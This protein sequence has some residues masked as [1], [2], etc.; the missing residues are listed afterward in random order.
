[1]LHRLV[2][3]LKPAAPLAVIL[4]LSVALAACGAKQEA[5]SGTGTGNSGASTTE[6]PRK[7]KHVMGKRRFRLTRG[8][9][10]C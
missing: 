5:S 3:R 6:G 8:V 2:H 9:W 1:M 7:I 10:W 4:C